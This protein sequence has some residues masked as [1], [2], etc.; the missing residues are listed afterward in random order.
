MNISAAKRLWK[1]I[2]ELWNRIDEHCQKVRINPLKLGICTVNPKSS[3]IGLPTPS[4]QLE[5]ENQARKYF[6]PLEELVGFYFKFWILPNPPPAIDRL[7][8]SIDDYEMSYEVP[9]YDEAW[10]RTMLSR[11][12]VFCPDI[13]ELSSVKERF[14]PQIEAIRFTPVLHQN[15]QESIQLNQIKERLSENPLPF[16]ESFVG[17]YI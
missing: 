5:L 9:L 11:C 12:L 3:G 6:D 7:E 17:Q 10:G 4:I 15:I 8:V 16:F 2:E 1:A 13:S 14:V